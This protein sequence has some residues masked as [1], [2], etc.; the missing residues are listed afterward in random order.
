MEQNFLI[1]TNIIIYY[2]ND[3]IPES[4]LEKTE[5]IFRESFHISTITKIKL[6]GCRKF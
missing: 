6:L 1:D 5:L 4:E 3:S 2:L